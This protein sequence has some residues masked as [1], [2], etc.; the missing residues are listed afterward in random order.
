MGKWN[1]LQWLVEDRFCRQVL[2]FHWDKNHLEENDFDKEG[3][4]YCAQ[5]ERRKVDMR[6]SFRIIMVKTI[7]GVVVEQV[8]C[9]K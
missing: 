5:K 1:T 6:S 3:I 8:L 4:G 9:R 2:F 7:E